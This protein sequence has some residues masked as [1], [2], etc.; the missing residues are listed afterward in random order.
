MNEVELPPQAP[1][2]FRSALEPGGHTREADSDQPRRDEIRRGTHVPDHRR[3]PDHHHAP[4]ES[5]TRRLR[6]RLPRGW[7]ADPPPA[8]HS[9]WS[10]ACTAA[11]LPNVIPHDMRRSAVR[12]LERA[13]VPRQV[14][15]RLVGHRTE[16]IY[17]RYAIV[18]EADIHEAGA[19]LDTLASTTKSLQSGKRG[20]QRR[21]GLPKNTE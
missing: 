10:D 9:E 20:G 19:S 3:A 18:S 5:R 13:R 21:R 12:Q 17:R 16:S 6:A 4:Q 2:S 14:A 11:N 7:T 8:V 15:M 1:G